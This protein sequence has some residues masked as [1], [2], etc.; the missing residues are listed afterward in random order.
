MANLVI[1]IPCILAALVLLRVLF[2][3]MKLIWKLLLNGISG[4]LLL[5]LINLTAGLTGFAIPINPVTAVIAGT[6]GFPG[7]LL[8]GILQFLF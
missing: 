5:W 6:L 8:L 2:L 4:V 7:F 1:I 3:P